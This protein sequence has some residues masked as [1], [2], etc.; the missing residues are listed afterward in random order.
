MNLKFDEFNS[1]ISAEHSRQYA[2]NGAENYQRI[3]EEFLKGDYSIETVPRFA[4]EAKVPALILGSGP[5]LDLSLPFMKDFPGIIFASPSQL[6]ILEK[7]EITPTY[8]V[9]IDAADDVGEVQ[10]PG[11]DTYGMTLLTHPY[12]SPKTLD[13]WHGSKKY[14]ELID[15]AGS[16]FKDIYPW[17]KTGFPVAGSV[18]NAQ[19]MIAYWMGCSPIILA[20]VDYCFPG[21]RTRAQ[22]YRKR[23]PYIFDPKPLEYCETREGLTSASP[24]TLFYAN[25]LLG[26]WKMYRA[27]LVQV[28]NQGAC[29]EIPFI[30]P[31]DICKPLDISGPGP[32]QIAAIDK[33][34]IEYGMFAEVDENGM[35]HFSWKEKDLKDAVAAREAEFIART[36]ADVWMKR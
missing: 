16:H 10:L 35:G 8:V 24:E 17:I 30:Q 21:G 31:E 23:G 7:W 28:S 29:T 12:I 22:D 2:K 1:R 13:A 15:E 4:P 6:S 19:V 14:F 33:S 5:S 36:R 3:K 27:P 26:I 11:H 20:G 34:M 9:A 25:I 18:N 32:D